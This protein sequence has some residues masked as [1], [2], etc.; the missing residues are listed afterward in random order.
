MRSIYLGLKNLLEDLKGC[1]SCGG[2]KPKKPVG[3]TLGGETIYSCKDA[4]HV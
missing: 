2:P 4:F 3:M 1:P